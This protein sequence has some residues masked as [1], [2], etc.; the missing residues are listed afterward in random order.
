MSGSPIQNSLRELWALFDFVMPGRLGTLPVFEERSRSLVLPSKMMQMQY[1][2]TLWL[3]NLG[4]D[5]LIKCGCTSV[6]K[7]IVFGCFVV[8]LRMFSSEIRSRCFLRSSR[9]TSWTP[10]SLAR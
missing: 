6:F 9:S 10:S 3:Y 1:F 8:D 5:W 4:S 2:L 7:I